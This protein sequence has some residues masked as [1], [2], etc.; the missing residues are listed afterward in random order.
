MSRCKLLN[1]CYTW[2]SYDTKHEEEE[3]QNCDESLLLFSLFPP[4]TFP[5]A[6]LSM[7]LYCDYLQFFADTAFVMCYIH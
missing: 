3:R 4:L 5:A 2:L 6:S 1:H 7:F